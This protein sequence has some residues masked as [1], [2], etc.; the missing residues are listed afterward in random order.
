MNEIKCPKCGEVFKVDEAGYADI[1]R[2]VRNDEFNRELR[3]R[4]EILAREHM[5][6]VELVE[7]RAETKLQER[8]AERDATVSQLKAQLDAAAHEQS[9]A[10][11]RERAEAA[12]RLQEELSKAKEEASKEQATMQR[13][14][15]ELRAQLGEQK[16][17][18]ELAVLQAVSTVEHE[19]D[20]LR[21]Q[22]E[23]ER[24]VR[25]AERKQLEASHTLELEQTK[26]TTGELMRYKDAEIE[27]LRDMKVRLST[28]MVGETLEQHCETEFNRLRM[29]A[30][31]HAYFEKDNDASEGTKG[32]YIFRECDE[33]G[34]EI[35]S[36]MFEMKNE[37]DDTAKK[38][39]NEEFFKKLDHDRTKKDCEYAVLVTLLE[40]ESELYNT[41]IVDVSYRYPKMYVIRPQFFIPLI[42]LLRNAALNALSYKQELAL[43]RQQNI[44]VT[45]FEDKLL[46]FQEGF[47][48]NYDLASRKFQTAIDEIDKSISHLQKIKDALISSDRNL[49]LANDKAQDLT[50]KKLTR[51][52]PTMKAAFEEAR[53]HA[54]AS[55]DDAADG[56]ADRAA[57]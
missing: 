8:I 32:D 25:A 23:Q 42:T 10:L 40:P 33:D 56:E 15:D 16:H 43:M 34:N 11:D 48:R 55:S 45:N 22:L 5:Q 4:E 14:A 27:R 1:V 37:G 9:L 44:D 30:F 21:A 49:R 3:E 41:G 51:G 38:H 6:E 54:A 2:Q 46:K 47:S 18:S 36:I 52:N 26:K 24:A 17:A 20:E 12:Q 53:Q 57:S 31:P 35:V 7:Q 28:K 19:R 29:S 13:E 50:I 39:K